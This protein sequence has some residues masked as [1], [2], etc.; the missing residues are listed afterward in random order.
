MIKDKKILLINNFC[1]PFG[2]AEMI[3]EKTSQLLS[4][5]NSI[6]FFATNKQPYFNN[7][8][9]NAE[10]FPQYVDIRSLK[11]SNLNKIFSFFYNHKAKSNLKKLI[12]LTKP[13]IAIIHNIHY[14]LTCSVIDAC[15]EKKIPII[16]YLHDPRF[17]C[18]GGLLFFKNQYCDKEYCIK[19][20]PIMCIKN[21]CKMG[22]LKNSILSALIF[23]FNRYKNF[24]NKAH[25]IICPSNAMKELAIR[26]GVDK[27]KL[28]VI[29]HFISQDQIDQ[30]ATLEIKD[31][32]YFLYAGRLSKE[33]GLDY[34]IEA[35][36]NLPHIKIH[37]AGKGEEEENLKN[38]VKKYNLSNVKFLG[39]LDENKLKE[40][41][42]NCTAT[43]LPCNWMEAFGLT[44]IESFL[45]KKPVI[46]SRIGAIPEL[47]DHNQNGILV[48]PGNIQE[49]KDAIRTL[50]QNKALA[51]QL[52]QNGRI[53][54]EKIYS[55]KE[56]L[57]KFINLC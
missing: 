13:D 2:G 52:G 28:K 25:V 26:S 36:K 9:S 3:L 34:L 50:H 39:Y 57:N 42:I 10:Y 23:S 38:K 45:Y 6:Q 32:N 49:L 8:P 22:N 12:N 56:F 44:I 33:K 20:N 18:P 54:L 35:I 11:I 24:L 37:I 53:K 31:K 5:T 14:H 17:F 46:G 29:N 41:Y 51:K 1:A 40:E 43:I 15:Y 16:L 47:I 4:K 30:T 27:N 48:E 21:K 19:G 55:E 7:T